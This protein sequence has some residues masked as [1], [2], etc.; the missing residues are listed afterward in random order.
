VLNKS[1][2][3]GVSFNWKSF[4]KLI[5]FFIFL[6]AVGLLLFLNEDS[7]LVENRENAKARVLKTDDSLLVSSGFAKIGHQKI[8]IKIL[9]GTHKGEVLD[10]ESHLNGRPDWDCWVKPGDKV[11]VALFYSKGV[12]VKSLVVEHNRRGALL[13]LFLSFS[14]VLLIYALFT[15]VRALFSFAASGIVIWYFLLPGLAKGINPLFITFIAIIILSTI[16]LFSIAGWT[17]KGLA[18]FLGTI[19][20][21]L[22]T[23]LLTLGF[24]ALLNLNGMTLPFSELVL[25]ENPLISFRNLFYSGIL[26]GAS[27]A[28][29][30]ISIDIAASVEEIHLK[31]MD[32]GAREL[33]KS[34]IKI[35]RSV[36]GTMTT[37]LLLAYSGGYLS[38]LLLFQMR[39]SSLMDVINMKI[40]AAEIMRTVVGSMGLV[41]VAPITAL[42]AAFLYSSNSRLHNWLR[43]RKRNLRRQR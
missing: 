14:V 1:F 43:D 21:L 27:G 24:G 29:M 23:S 22:L 35:G 9:N 34:G 4:F 40:V 41:L 13:F 37:T 15:G 28:A 17:E 30:D 31:R 12:I 20:G 11:L 18:A 25:M 6:S 10:A 5:P 8:T 32:L 19:G 26:I 33:F 2:F 7:P 38:L 42:F 39:S 16:I 36:I 3:K